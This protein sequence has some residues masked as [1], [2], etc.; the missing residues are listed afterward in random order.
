MCCSAAW[1]PVTGVLLPRVAIVGSFEHTCKKLSRR[2]GGRANA[3]DDGADDAA[4]GFTLDGFGDLTQAERRRS[5][6]SLDLIG[7][8]LQD[9]WPA[10][11]LAA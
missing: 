8:P 7:H 4:A 3:L 1:R 11:L 10:E 5:R 2:S 9:L 6:Q